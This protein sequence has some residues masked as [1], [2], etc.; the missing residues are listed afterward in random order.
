MALDLLRNEGF[1]GDRKEA[2]NIAIV[3]TDGLSTLP[4]QTVI[5][6][7]SLKDAGTTA[8]AIGTATLLNYIKDL[9]SLLLMLFGVTLLFTALKLLCESFM[10]FVF[11]N[12]SR[13][14]L[15]CT[16]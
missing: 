2:P 6:A 9:K 13:Y 4:D 10:F 12:L 7:K 15:T 1:E 16:Y 3:I 11:F 5:A 14:V 8:F